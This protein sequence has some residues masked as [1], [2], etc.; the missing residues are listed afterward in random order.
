MAEGKIT[1]GQAIDKGIEAL[2]GLDQ[3]ARQTA[4]AAIC[5]HLNLAA[6]SESLQHSA[7]RQQAADALAVHSENPPSSTA[8]ATRL[9]DIRTL[10]TEKKPN[11][12]RQMACLVAYYLSECAPEGERKEAVT[13]SD[14]EK[15]FKQAGYRLPSSMKDILP[16]AKKAGYF[17]SGGS[18]GSYKLN[19]VGHNLVVHSMPSPK[20]G[21]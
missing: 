12:A 18:R 10:K 15:Y 21:D 14:L 2:E 1:L 17:E 7:S 5:S 8:P 16:N 9:V 3:G 19:A 6:P 11:S 13:P 4:L 20:S